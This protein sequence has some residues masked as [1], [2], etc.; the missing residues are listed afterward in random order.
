MSFLGNFLSFK[1]YNP[2]PEDKVTIRLS[3]SW[4]SRKYYDVKYRIENTKKWHNIYECHWY[5][6]DYIYESDLRIE[7]RTE[8]QLKEN[9]N[10]YKNKFKTYQDILDYENLGL[11]TKQQYLIYQQKYDFL[12]RIYE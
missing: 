1:K 5:G 8:E 2:K 10:E 7:F 11:R 9:L 3:Q 12:N 6:N 4:F